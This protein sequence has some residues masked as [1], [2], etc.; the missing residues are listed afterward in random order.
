MYVA[1]LQ[2]KFLQTTYAELDVM[3]VGSHISELLF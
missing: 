1:L 3:E 2:T